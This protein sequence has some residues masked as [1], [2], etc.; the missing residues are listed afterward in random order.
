MKFAEYKN[1]VLNELSMTLNAV[2]EKNVEEIVEAILSA[3][4]IFVNGVGRSGFMMRCFTM[5]LMHLGLAVY[6]LGE[7]TTSNTSKDDL[8]IIGSGSGETLS[9]LTQLKKAKQIG[10]KVALIT[11]S[12]DCSMGQLANYIIKIPAPTSKIKTSYS[13]IQPMGNLFEQSLLVTSEIIVMKL[14]KKMGNTSDEMFKN[15]ANLE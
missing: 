8:L 15:H 12:G 14:M 11:I 2:T 3:K 9:L 13:S 7:T 1:K 4:K 6:F 10:C 5:R